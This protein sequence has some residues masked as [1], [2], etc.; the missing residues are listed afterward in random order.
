MS[1]NRDEVSLCNLPSSCSPWTTVYSLLCLHPHLQVLTL[2]LT[3]AAPHSRD[4][5]NLPGKHNHPRDMCALLHN[6]DLEAFICQRIKAMLHTHMHGER[7]RGKEMERERER[8]REKRRE[9]DRG[10]MEGEK[11]ERELP[12]NIRKTVLDRDT[13][14]SSL[15]Y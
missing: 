10:E 4:A 2:C 11:R 5:Y 9:I 8:E 1:Q 6:P 15:S 7:G 13:Y 3:P 14:L 12:L